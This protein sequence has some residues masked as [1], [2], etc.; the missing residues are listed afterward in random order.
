MICSDNVHDES[1]DDRPARRV[2]ISAH[3]GGSETAPPGTWAA[4]VAALATPADYVEIDVRR[5]LDGTWVVYHHRNVNRVGVAVAELHYDQL[6]D[7]AGYSVPLATDVMELLAPVVLGHVDLK[8]TRSERMIVKP[9]IDIF[10]KDGFLVSTESPSSIREINSYEP[11]VRTALSFGFGVRTRSRRKPARRGRHVALRR[12]ASL[13]A[14]RDVWRCGADSIAIN[15]HV[16]SPGM[17]RQCRLNGLTVLLW[18]VNDSA[19][20]ARYLI[21][22]NVAVLITDRP[23]HAGH[24]RAAATGR[25]AV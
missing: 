17:L 11:A 20:I 23:I 1:R 4:F 16:A 5:T 15:H 6:C 22:P 10:G 24:L 21:D 18:T 8:E 13:P 3:R 12:Q 9:A 19:R 7:V 2:A 14:L 25:A